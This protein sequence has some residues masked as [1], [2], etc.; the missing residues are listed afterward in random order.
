[1]RP[2]FPR[3]SR[4]PSPLLRLATIPFVLMVWG[5]LVAA[6][7]TPTGSVN[8]YELSLPV[9]E[10]VYVAPVHVKVSAAG[11]TFITH[12]AEAGRQLILRLLGMKERISADLFKGIVTEAVRNQDQKILLPLIHVALTRGDYVEFDSSDI[13]DRMATVPLVRGGLRDLMEHEGEGAIPAR[14][15]ECAQALAMSGGELPGL[16]A[17]IADTCISRAVSGALDRMGQGS[18]VSE[19]ASYVSRAHEVFGVEARS[20]AVQAQRLVG[21]LDNLEQSINTSDVQAFTV[22]LASLKGWAMRGDGSVAALTGSRLTG[23][24]IEQAFRSERSDSIVLLLPHINPEQRTPMLHAAVA[25][26]VRQMSSQQ[27]QDILTPELWAAL[28]IYV[29]K[30]E[31]VAA[32]VGEV[33]QRVCE[34]LIAAGNAEAAYRF[35]VQVPVAYVNVMPGMRSTGSRVIDG[36]LDSRDPEQ[37][38]RAA[39]VIIFDHT[40]LRMVRVWLARHGLSFVGCIVPI[41]LI[42]G[43]F[44]AWRCRRYASQSDRRLGRGSAEGAGASCDLPA[45]FVAGLALFGL[46]PGAT[47]ADLKVAYRAAVKRC[48]PDR[49]SGVRREDPSDFIRLTA[50]YQRLVGLYDEFERS[51]KL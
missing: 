15:C 22:A 7:A 1:M 10:L 32:R 17:R 4:K 6:E 40:Y 48:H 43:F 27:A 24:F 42:G 39:E 45:D 20:E 47:K 28:G 18:S 51:A 41:G 38:S 5:S 12:Q 9:D 16:I 13:W 2:R 3:T 21:D 11:G 35:L 44:V 30:D 50:E 8:Y 31:E 26:S 49:D 19:V 34:S 33:V 29:E 14:L 37:V 25:E 46:S 23:R 36:L